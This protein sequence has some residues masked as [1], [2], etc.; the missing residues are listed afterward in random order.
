MYKELVIWEHTSE[1]KKLS[2]I[3]EN[4]EGEPHV[5][6]KYRGKLT[7]IMPSR[8]LRIF[9]TTGRDG[10]L[11]HEDA[12]IIALV[13]DKAVLGYIDKEGKVSGYPIEELENIKKI[14]VRNL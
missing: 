10:E 1:G 4:P 9:E 14:G 6:I 12:K 3:E 8:V 11:L 7:P 2:P 5:V 13:E